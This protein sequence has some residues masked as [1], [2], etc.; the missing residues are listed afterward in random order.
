MHRDLRRVFPGLGLIDLLPW[1]HEVT[2]MVADQPPLGRS[3][4]EGNEW[5]SE[6]ALTSA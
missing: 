6:G 4:L 2:V 3:A 5:S 1:R